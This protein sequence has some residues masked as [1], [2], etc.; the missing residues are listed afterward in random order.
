[1]KTWAPQVPTTPLLEAP[2]APLEDPRKL[3]EEADKAVHAFFHEGQSRNTARTY[4]TALQYWGAWHALRYG[5]PIEGP[6]PPSA[7]IQFIVDH[8]EHQP[9]L[10]A[11]AISPYT[12][13]SQTTQHLLPLAIDRVLVD[14]KYKAHLGPWSIATVQT[15]LAALSKAHEH[16]IANHAHLN[17]GPEINP[18]R[19]PS[20][21]QLI[22]A[23][24]RAYA[25][26]GRDPVR[27]VAATR[28]VMG[29]LVATCGED[30]A[31]KRDRALLLFGWASGG[32]RRSE[33]AE[34][35]FENVRRDGN[36]LR[37]RTP[38][39]QDQPERPQG[40]EKLQAHPGHRGGRPSGL[41]RRAPAVPNH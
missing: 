9:H 22:G 19:D 33:I 7:V 24:R 34:A 38:P 37:V 30:L 27:P 12:P 41:D 4:R 11:P 13:S 28:S 25:R 5:A 23:A 29:A 3:S 35:S 40:S 31:G 17:L 6:V 39:F 18:L 20:L 26:R 1:M 32:R 2:L 15:R 10:A 14:R 8:L 36:W 21:R 16:Y